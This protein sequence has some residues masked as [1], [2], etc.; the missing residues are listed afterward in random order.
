MARYI[1]KCVI[2]SC[3]ITDA[4][5]TDLNLVTALATQGQFKY[6]VKGIVMNAHIEPCI[7][8]DLSLIADSFHSRTSGDNGKSG[9]FFVV[10]HLTA[11]FHL[12]SVIVFRDFLCRS[13][14]VNL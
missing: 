8:S 5:C 1:R 11:H 3:D 7:V 14:L 9:F 2:D 13:H 10:E 4:V 6:V 12:E